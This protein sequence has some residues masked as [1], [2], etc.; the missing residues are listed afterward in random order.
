MAVVVTGANRPDMTH[1]AAL[2]AAAVGEPA[3]TGPPQ[4]VLDRGYAYASCRDAAGAR[5]DTPP[6]PPA[7]SAERPLPPPGDPDRHPPRRR[8]VEAARGWFNRVRRLR[9][10]WKNRAATDLG[11]VHLAAILIISRKVRHARSPSG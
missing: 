1:L 8:V 4:R 6:V 7:A 11:F 10:R 2:R 5:G 9:T 3:P